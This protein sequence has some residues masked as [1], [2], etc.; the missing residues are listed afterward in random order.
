MPIFFANLLAD[1]M[2]SNRVTDINI[3]EGLVSFMYFNTESVGTEGDILN[4][5]NPFSK[6]TD[7]I[8]LQA[9]LWSSPSGVHIT[10][11]SVLLVCL[12]SSVILW[13]ALFAVL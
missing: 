4:T 13:T 6:R 7:S 8:M 9:I 12:Y 5:L 1:I 10:T 3:K 11:P 2:L